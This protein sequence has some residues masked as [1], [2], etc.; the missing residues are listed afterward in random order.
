MVA[1]R[2]N[3][4]RQKQEWSLGQITDQDRNTRSFRE[5]TEICMVL[6][7]NNRPRQKNTRSFQETTDQ[8]TVIMR[9]NTPRQ[10]HTVLQR[11]NRPRQNKHTVTATLL[12]STRF[13]LSYPLLH[14]KHPSHP[15]RRYSQSPLWPRRHWCTVTP[16]PSQPPCTSPPSPPSPHSLPTK[17]CLIPPPPHPHPPSLPISARG[18]HKWHQVPAVHKVGAGLQIPGDGLGAEVPCGPIPHED[19]PF[20][21][22]HRL[23][24]VRGQHPRVERVAG[25]GREI[26]SLRLLFRRRLL[27]P[28]PHHN[29]PH[30]SPNHPPPPQPLSVYFPDPRNLQTV[31][32][33]KRTV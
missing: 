7:R 31:G 27:S 24:P 1:S 8:D 26:E 29:P 17:C 3:R 18:S 19:E 28:F 5:T 4:P 6:P 23:S 22:P 10:K 32:F 14:T 30:P 13:E 2:D 33:T 12:S 9:D 25:A 11:N 20:V 16:P 21:S 15:A